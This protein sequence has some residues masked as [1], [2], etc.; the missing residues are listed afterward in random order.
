MKFLPNGFL[1]KRCLHSKKVKNFDAVII[2]GGH[3]GLVAA[4]YLQKNG[5]QVFIFV[6][7]Y[8]LFLMV[9][10]FSA[11]RFAFWKNEIRSEEQR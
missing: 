5:F 1:I 9:F 7:F 11:F 10:F 2:G 6:L 3:N 4:A 8:Q